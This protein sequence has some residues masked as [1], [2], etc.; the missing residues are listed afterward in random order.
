MTVN[1]RIFWVGQLE[2]LN[3]IETRKYI[4]NKT[5]RLS[6]TGPSANDYYIT[7][8]VASRSHSTFMQ[9]A[10]QR[11][12]IVSLA[13]D[14]PIYSV[15]EYDARVGKQFVCSPHGEGERQFITQQYCQCVTVT[16]LGTSSSSS[17]SSSS[18]I[19]LKY[20][21]MWRLVQKLQ[22]NVGP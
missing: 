17:S 14:R 19:L 13:S 3:G 5:A 11:V 16:I 9:P 8:A 7:A 18:I 2:C 12:L 1:M 15:V 21:F 4:D 20:R 22:G 6:S 10:V